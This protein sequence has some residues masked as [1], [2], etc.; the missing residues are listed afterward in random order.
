MRPCIALVLI[1]ALCCVLSCQSPPEVTVL[2]LERWQ[3]HAVADLPA[4]AMY[5]LAGDLDGDSD[6]DIVAGG[7]WW[8]N[9]GSMEGEWL[10]RTVGEPFRNLCAIHDFDRDGDL[11]LIGTEGVGSESNRRFVWAQNDGNG[12]FTVLSNIDSC[13]SGDFL[14][15]CTLADFGR[16]PAV[17]LAWHRGGLG[18]YLIEVPRRPAQEIWPVTRISET[19]QKEDLS[20]GDI[21]RDGDVDLLLGTQWLRN[22]GSEWSAFTLGQVTDLDEDAEPDRNDLADVNG[23]GRLDAVIALE[24]ATP[25][26][27]FEAPEDPT[28]PWTRHVIDQVDGQGFSM[29]TRDFDRDGDP[30]IVIGEHRGPEVN[31]V[32]LYENLQGGTRWMKY[33]VD[34]GAKTEIDHHDGTQAV[35]LD[36]DGDLDLISVG[37]YNPKVWVFENQAIP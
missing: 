31:R 32:L 20:A 11:D 13:E 12:D 35:D 3:R 4:R 22:D 1:T 9:P 17:A 33:V 8:L 15:G 30:D 29:D 5:I 36:N 14:Q 19:T 37:W 16:G 23:D 24:L 25:L 27:W 26:L 7:H 2:T 10:Q 21:D 34:Q 6:A 18:T 28:R